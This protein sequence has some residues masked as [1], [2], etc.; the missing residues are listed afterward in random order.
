MVETETVLCDID[1]RYETLC[2]SFVS[3]ALP[4]YA[5]RLFIL[6]NASSE[7]NF[8]GRRIVIQ[9]PRPVQY[10]N[11]IKI[12]AIRQNKRSLRAESAHETSRRED[13]RSIVIRGCGLFGWTR[14]PVDH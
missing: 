14:F 12:H 5:E 9:D 13:I 3:V 8:G 6:Q 7:W 10:V 4:S 2:R 1:G 11:N